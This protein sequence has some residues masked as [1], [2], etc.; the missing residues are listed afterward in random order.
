MLDF[1]VRYPRYSQTYPHFCT[2][3]GEEKGIAVFFT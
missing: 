3:C 2:F 1:D